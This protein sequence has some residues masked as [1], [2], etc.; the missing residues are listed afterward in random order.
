MYI[1]IYIRTVTGRKRMLRGR[2][3]GR[4]RGN[5]N[6]S[7]AARLFVYNTHIYVYIYMY[8]HICIY[9]HIYTHSDGIYVYTYIYIHIVTGRKGMM[10]DKKG[11]R[12]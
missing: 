10:R 12:E 8:I 5:K 7:H 4:E 3:G 1:Y 11:G 2:E 9:V 6:D